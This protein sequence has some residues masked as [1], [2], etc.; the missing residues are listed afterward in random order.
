MI[1]EWIFKLDRYFDDTWLDGAVAVVLAGG[2][3]V[4]LRTV[5]EFLLG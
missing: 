2:L 1:E 5:V 4:S 3:T